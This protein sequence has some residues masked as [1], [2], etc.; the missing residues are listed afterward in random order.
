MNTAKTLPSPDYLNECFVFRD[1]A[2]YWKERPR[3]HFNSDRAFSMWNAKFAGRSAGR[4]MANG[5]GYVQIGVDLERHL[6]H[7]LI[8]HMNGLCVGPHDVVDHIDGNPR[9]NNAN[10]LRVCTQAQNTR[11]N[12]GWHNKHG[13]VGVYKLSDGVWSASIRVDGKLRHLGRFLRE[14]D[15]VEARRVAEL[16]HYGQFSKAARDLATAFGAEHGV[17]WSDVEEMEPA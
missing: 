1:A 7:R 11:N 13:R 3:T 4:E 2:L 8:A 14:E 15:A 12:S 9:N 16:T 10:N 6:A 17:A 5:R